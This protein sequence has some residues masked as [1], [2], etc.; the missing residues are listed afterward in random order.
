VAGDL[1][2]TRRPIARERF[3]PGEALIAKRGLPEVEEDEHD[4]FT[5]ELAATGHQ[6]AMSRWVE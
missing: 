6:E 1:R 3:A 4:K 5:R 2:V